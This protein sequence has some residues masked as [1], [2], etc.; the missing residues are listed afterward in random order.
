M[1]KIFSLALAALTAAGL[2]SCQDDEEYL[3]AVGI[4]E[5]SVTPGNSVIAFDEDVNQYKATEVTVAWDILNEQLA[6]ATLKVTPTIGTAV[7]YNGE[8][9]TEE[10]VVVD[11]ADGK[12]VTL[13]AA[14]AAAGITKDYQFTARI[15][16]A[17][18]GVDLVQKSSSMIENGLDPD[19]YDFDVAHFN[20]NFY[21]VTAALS[22]E[23]A[24]YGLYKSE[25]GVKWEK[26]EYVY[27]NGEGKQ[28]SIGGLGAELVVANGRMYV[29]G[30]A[31][32][33]G[34]TEFE[35]APEEFWGMP[36]IKAWRC[37]S[38]ADGVNFEDE[39]LDVRIDEDQYY[40]WDVNHEWPY[41]KRYEPSPASTEVSIVSVDGKHF[42]FG[43]YAPT[44]GMMQVAYLAYYTEDF[45]DWYDDKKPAYIPEGAD[46]GVN[47]RKRAAFFEFKG[48]A[49]CVGGLL[50]HFNAEQDNNKS[51]VLSSADGM[52][53]KQEIES[54]IFGRM[55]GMQVVAN[56][57]VAYMFGGEKYN[58][59]GEREVSDKVYRSINGYNW[60][61]I[62][63]PENYTARRNPVVVRVG[64][65]AWIFG[66]AKNPSSND[67]AFYDSRDELIFDTWVKQLK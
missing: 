18:G 2:W 60:E 33:Y 39:T 25:D 54:D 57:K 22:G 67:Q 15:N 23:T 53:W 66:G 65:A 4:L 35:E 61:E 42:C 37:A 10:G 32:L 47:S 12:V 5:V 43:G 1:K 19:T 17:S 44:F 56:D 14:N 21:A 59:S 24:R 40:D 6:E 55:C 30:G 20:G 52:T 27:K 9:V 3:P 41:D 38:T 45:T 8:A 13:T 51:D 29:L 28:Q 48:K 16:S 64:D 46:Y 62:E 63:M 49:W 7:T 11:L 34:T 26:V 50:N 31:R 36:E 58:D